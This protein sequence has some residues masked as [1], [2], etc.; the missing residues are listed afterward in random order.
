MSWSKLK[1]VSW[2]W[3]FWSISCVFAEVYAIFLAKDDLLEKLEKLHNELEAER[4]SKGVLE[5]KI[6]AQSEK[7]NDNEE[8]QRLTQ[9]LEK[10][11]VKYTE[12]LQQEEDRRQ[13]A[14][15]HWKVS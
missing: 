15:E 7:S 4:V 2:E 12:T 5:N 10:L 3:E 8:I 6:Q 1:L 9:E 14:L 11:E 13:Q